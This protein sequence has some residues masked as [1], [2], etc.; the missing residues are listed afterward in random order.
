MSIDSKLT[1]AGRGKAY[2]PRRYSFASI[3]T[4]LISLS[5]KVS[6][7]GFSFVLAVNI[8]SVTTL[9]SYRTSSIWDYV[10]ICM[11]LT[12]LPFLENYL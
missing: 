9:M 3:H 2:P 4:V 6:A 10:Y 5:V 11:T 12:A 7:L 8:S 1:P